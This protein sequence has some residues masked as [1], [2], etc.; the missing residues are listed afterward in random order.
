MLKSPPDPQ[1]KILSLS[2]VYPNLSEP[3]AGLFIRARLEHMAAAADVKV[4]APILC[5]DD[6]GRNGNKTN[7]ARVPR[8]CQSGPLEV[9]HPRWLYVPGTGVLTALLLAL[10]LIWPVWRLRK[11]FPFQLL[12]AHF[13][14]PEGIAAALLA[15]VLRLPF[16][17]TLRGS[18][19]LHA[20]YRWR[21]MGMRWALRRAS[22]VLT[23]SE[24]LRIFALELGVDPGRVK[25]IPNGI[26]RARFH[27]REQEVSRARYG[28]PT[29]T[30]I[31]LAAG[32]LI[33]LKGHHHLIRA[34]KQLLA[35]GSHV[36]L[37]IAGGVPG[38]GV[39][40]YEAELRALTAELRLQEAVRFLGP[41]SPDTLAELM[42]AADV[43]C[44]ASSREGW[45][46]VVNEALG[47]GTPVVATH[48]GAIPE[49]IPSARY[50][51]VVPVGDPAALAG[52]VKLALA[53]PWD[54]RAIAAWGQTRGWEEVAEEVLE[55]VQQIL[56][57][58][59]QTI[60]P[61]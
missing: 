53:T 48:V 50:G 5:L 51:F 8:Y 45:P 52:A 19:L 24:Q 54:R 1:P 30:P 40:S 7:R 4:V 43:F 37:L 47:C 41:V 14:F 38:R 18:E 39:S 20:R 3:G 9:Y 21:R 44:L 59:R 32:H 22:R 28:L 15:G 23:V 16:M 6:V 13:G 25:T 60:P 56:G 29:A 26:D 57:E 10:E 49:L 27:P 2:S 61:A 46:N 17:V 11:R 12:D 35:G 58:T 36:L 31:I 42:S 55:Q 33:E 34:M